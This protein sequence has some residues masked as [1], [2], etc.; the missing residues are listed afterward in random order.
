MSNLQELR[1]HLKELENSFEIGSFTKENIKEYAKCFFM[2][3]SMFLE[4]QKEEQGEENKE[5]DCHKEQLLNQ[6]DK[7][8]KEELIKS[9]QTSIAKNQELEKISFEK[10]EN[11]IQERV[12]PKLKRI[13]THK[14]QESITS[15]I[16][17]QLESFKKDELDLS[18]VFEIQRKNTQIAYR[19]A[20]GGLIG[21]IALSIAI[22]IM[23]PLKENTPYF[24]DFA[25]SDKHFA[26]VQR[27]DTKVDYGEAFLR[28]LVGSYITTRETINH[29]DDKIRL[30]ET[31]R[32]QSSEEVWKT[33]EQLVSGKGSIY[34]NSNMDR[35]IKIINISIY[36]QGKQQNIAVADIVANVFDKGYL[37]SEK[38][39]RVSLI[40]HFKP[41]IQFDYSSMP[42]NPTGF[43]VDKYSLSEI[44]SIKALDKTYKKV[45][46]PHSKIEYKK[47][48]PTNPQ[49]NP[50]NMPNN[51]EEQ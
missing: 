46:R 11:K 51:K 19:L 49:N 26:V 47:Q 14:L 44:A 5:K 12:L 3:L 20:I 1:E 36:K 10:W 25:N 41:L 15:S 22:F 30:N 2:G 13:V 38:R 16:N 32:E 35:E 21:I 27:A 18:S 45:E 8:Y 40:Y 7:E 34:S 9:I 17:T 37:I 6:D 28:S 43:I 23:M 24:I 31:I 29:I 33:L 4:Q 50:A 39:Y 42:K 48:N